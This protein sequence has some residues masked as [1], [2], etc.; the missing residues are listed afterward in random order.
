MPS[1]EDSVD[2]YNGSPNIH[3]ELAFSSDYMNKMTNLH[4]FIFILKNIEEI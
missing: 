2:D 4:S 3:E 1:V